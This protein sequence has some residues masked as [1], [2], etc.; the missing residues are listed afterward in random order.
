MTTSS[1]RRRRVTTT[2]ADR[3]LGVFIAQRRHQRNL[4]QTELARLSGLRGSSALSRLESG[5]ADHISRD[6]IEA[7]AQVLEGDENELWSA[8]G[9]LPPHAV[10][11]LR[12]HW[13][14]YDAVLLR[15]YTQPA[16]RRIHLRAVAERFLDT[17]NIVRAA[18]VDINDLAAAIT[19]TGRRVRRISA[20]SPSV[21]YDSRTIVVRVSAP[22]D[23]DPL[24]DAG[25]PAV[26]AAVDAVER[27][28]VVYRFLAAHAVAHI[29][30]QPDDESSTCEWPHMTDIEVVADEL[31]S[32]LLAPADILERAFRRAVGASHGLVD[33]W[34]PAAGALVDRVAHRVGAPA[35]LV[36]RRLAEDD[37]LQM[38]AQESQ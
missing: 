16:V 37:L 35:W 22:P 33:G 17:T 12:S 1:V 11:A 15:E 7:L 13:G 24:L 10:K 28:D 5:L 21:V 14:A 38:H 2:P 19:P 31:A 6:L 4:T 36:L 20:A 30:L 18:K 8:A 25:D 27:A 9:V 23:P 29:L 34:H 26:Q 32:H 3:A